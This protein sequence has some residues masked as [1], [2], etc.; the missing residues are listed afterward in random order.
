V[1]FDRTIRVTGISSTE[2]RNHELI[3]DKIRKAKPI[4][5]S[6]P[7]RP[8]VLRRLVVS[9][10]LATLRRLLPDR[11]RE[12]LSL[13]WPGLCRL[14]PGNSAAIG[15]KPQC[16]LQVRAA[17]AQSQ[18]DAGERFNAIESVIESGA[19]DVEFVRGSANVAPT[20][21]DRPSGG[22]QFITRLGQDGCDS[23]MYV[24][25]GERLGRIDHE[26]P[27]TK[28]VPGDRVQPCAGS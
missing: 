12:L 18:V 17:R 26:P 1:L 9:R 6:G 3:F 2:N 24:D 28:L 11:R 14:I 10:L 8:S 5:G 15:I 16:E 13:A 23:R 21:K 27:C 22:K 19:V 4:G 7:A 20:V 25:G